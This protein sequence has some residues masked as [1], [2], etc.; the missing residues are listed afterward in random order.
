MLGVGKSENRTLGGSIEASKASKG[1][2]LFDPRGFSWFLLLDR[3]VGA[4]EA[5]LFYAGCSCP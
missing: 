2:G 4:L 1:P 5:W 3:L